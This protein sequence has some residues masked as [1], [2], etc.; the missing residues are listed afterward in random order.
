[1]INS[2]DSAYD[3]LFAEYGVF[4]LLT[5]GIFYAGFFVKKPDKNSYTLPLVFLLLGFFVMGY[6]FEQ[7]SVVILFEL[8]MFLDIKERKI[9]LSNEK[10]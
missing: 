3:Q 4:G 6:W 9:E 10:R 8:L 2:P 1:M 5:F 7:L